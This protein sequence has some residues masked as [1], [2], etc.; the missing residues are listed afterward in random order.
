MK[1]LFNR[2]QN[3]QQTSS[4]DSGPPETF[5]EK[6]LSA[7]HDSMCDLED[8]IGPEA[9]RKVWDALPHDFK[10]DYNWSTWKYHS[11]DE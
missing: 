5:S 6:D 9:V 1:R 2:R 4:A 7:V 3:G 11:R 8:V 10:M